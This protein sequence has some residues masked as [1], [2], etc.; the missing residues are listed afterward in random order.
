MRDVPQ[1]AWDALDGVAGFPFLSWAWLDALERTGCVGEDA[2]WVPHHV[3]LWE[4][5]R[6][7]AAAPAYLKDNSEGEFVFDYAWANAA[8]RAGLR[9]YP[10]LCVA[11]PFTPATGARLLVGRST[12]RVRLGPVFATAL[13]RL[14]EEHG[15]S[16][17]HV[18][19]PREDEALLLSGA[20]L[21][22]RY[23]VQF[24]WKNAGYGSF[25]DFLGRFPSKRRNQIRRERRSM[26]DQRIE[27]Q[28]LRG[29]DI[30]P[31]VVDAMYRF[32]LST[33]DKF[34]WGRRYLNRAFFEEACVAVPGV[35]IVLAQGPERRAL[36][37][38]F[39]LAGERVL[40]GR[41]WGAENGRHEPERPFLHFNVC[42]YHSIDDCI[43]R[44]LSSFEPGAGGSHKVARG[45]DPTITHSVH[46]IAVP[47]LDEAIRAFLARERAMIRRAVD[48]GGDAFR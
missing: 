48:E 20:G 4:D 14:V 13:R 22:H 38:A 32:Y 25:D 37:G 39:N 29:S 42:Y 40:Y 6:M 33:V 44:G 24:Q 43:T 27:I 35:E 2:G 47:E 26:Q 45:F 5:G 28:T 18:L 16:S 21:S 19:F 34:T 12:D 41:Y 23:G 10:K 9:Y 17:A 30:T 36:A 1:P 11:V 8:H 3:T 15:I 46:H 31:E 7:V